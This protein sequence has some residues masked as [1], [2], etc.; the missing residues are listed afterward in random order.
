MMPLT[1]CLAILLPLLALACG[2]PAPLVNVPKD[3][4]NNNDKNEGA[5]KEK[6]KEY[7]LKEKAEA[8]PVV[9]SLMNVA[10]IE[11]R[12]MWSLGVIN[13]SERV[14]QWKPVEAVAED[15][16]G[17]TYR[18]NPFMVM[19]EEIRQASHAAIQP[20]KATVDSWYTKDVVQNG[21]PLRLKVWL[22]TGGTVVFLV[23]PEDIQSH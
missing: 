18:R 5:A 14:V 8:G 13:T 23:L 11:G 4:G 2:A 9:V 16:V 1:R 12:V 20:R 21:K 7:R 19:P 15:G 17:N 10:R 3:G 22:P 6:P